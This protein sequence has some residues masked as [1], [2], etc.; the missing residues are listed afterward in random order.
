MPTGKGQFSSGIRADPRDFPGDPEATDPKGFPG[1]PVAPNPTGLI[2]GL[3]TTSH[4]QLR[5]QMLQLKI[6]SAAINI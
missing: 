5:V 6:P 1:D 2:P 3:G 4:M